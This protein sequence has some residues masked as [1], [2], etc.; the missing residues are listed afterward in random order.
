MK[1]AIIDS[2]A[3]AADVMS[4]VAQR[5]GHQA[6]VVPGAGKL[7]ERLPFQPVATVLSVTA[8]DEPAQRDIAAL[9]RRFPESYLVVLC[10]RPGHDG[11]LEALRSGADDVVRLPVH[12]IE[13]FQRIE[14]QAT[15]RS[16]RPVALAGGRR[17]ADLEIDLDAH[18]AS[19]AGTAMVLTKLERRLLFCLVEHHP[20]VATLDRLLTFGWESVDEP[21]AGLLK[22]HISH[23]R[24][25]LKD[26]GGDPIEIVSHQTVGYSIRE[27]NATAASQTA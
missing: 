16:G 9:R 3:T 20:N 5:R 19:K 27:V 23:I 24:R 17:F 4:F 6:I 15:P 25:K 8:I 14:R 22:T 12:P 26:A 1:L 10:E 2:D 21:E 11:A 7:E 18:T 13:L